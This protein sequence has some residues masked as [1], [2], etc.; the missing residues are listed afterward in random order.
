MVTIKFGPSN[1]VRIED[2]TWRNVGA[3]LNDPN[4]KGILKYGSNV[5]AVHDGR[6]LGTSD[7]VPN[8]AVIDIRSVANGKG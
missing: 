6:V 1:E 7:P 8:S 5:E 4:V 3:M 2:P